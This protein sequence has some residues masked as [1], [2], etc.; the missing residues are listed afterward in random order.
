M[1]KKIINQN[2]N[3]NIEL[4]D[5]I[6]SYFIFEN[7]PINR[8]K[9]TKI[10]S[11]KNYNEDGLNKEQKLNKLKRKINSIEDCSIKNNSK[12]IILGSGNINS[13]IMLVGET[14]GE[15][16]EKIG[17]AFLGEVGELLKVEVI[18]TNRN[19]PGAT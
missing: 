12:N 8:F 11:S 19:S 16:E 17:E 7:K 10:R 9:N 13:P 14:P 1:S 6:E 18:D 15:E 2:R 4:L 3:Y 5:S